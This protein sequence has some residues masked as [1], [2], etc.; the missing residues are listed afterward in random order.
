M[1]PLLWLDVHSGVHRVERGLCK[2]RNKR[3]PHS[4]A[5]LGTWCFCGLSSLTLLPTFKHQQY[6]LPAQQIHH[7]LLLFAEKCKMTQIKLN[8]LIH[9]NCFTS[10]AFG[11]TPYATPYYTVCICMSSNLPSIVW[12]LPPQA[13][14]VS[15][16]P[17]P[18]YQLNRVSSQSKSKL[19]G[20]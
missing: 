9:P 5:S 15:C 7:S 8:N 20:V 1:H 18:K 4:N 14:Q 16:L 12:C 11:S 19:S 10:P 6:H 17:P 3:E 13:S 2:G